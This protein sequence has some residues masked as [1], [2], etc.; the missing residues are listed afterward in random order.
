MKKTMHYV[1]HETFLPFFFLLAHP[2][3][4]ETEQGTLK[5]E[6]EENNPSVCSEMIGMH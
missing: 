5:A 2:L 1:H 6:K 3:M 4:A